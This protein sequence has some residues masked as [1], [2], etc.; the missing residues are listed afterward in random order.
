VK[1]V[2]ELS[3]R[4]FLVTGANTGI[5]RAT[6]TD[7]AG[8]GGR[9]FLACRS[10][11]KGEAAVAQIAAVTGSAEV[12]LLQ[13]DLADL[14]SVRECARAFLALEEPLHVLVNNAG[15]G[16]TPGRTKDGFELVFGV[17]HLGH[18]ALTMGLLDCLT[19]CRARIVNVAS[20]A[21]YE[22]KG[23]DFDRLRRR[24][25]GITGMNE[26]AVSKLC[27]VLF[28]QE[29]A[30]RLAGT[31]VVSYSLHPGVVASDIWRRV[32]GPVRPLVTRRMLTVEQGARTSLYCAT[33]PEAA[34]R[35]GAYYDDCIQ[36]QPSQVATPE[37]GELLWRHSET[38]AN[39]R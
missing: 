1:W 14:A 3:G 19:A 25:R 31:G 8:R 30:R 22:A 28:S 17:N 32:P 21:H 9:V 15:V 10:R 39:G 36:K 11:Q 34:L 35:S 13:L 16:G 24:T 29:L 20:Q 4:T 5:G 18:F 12:R 27:N 26:Y 6:A 37:L 7:L 33:A 38:W 23:I 2:G